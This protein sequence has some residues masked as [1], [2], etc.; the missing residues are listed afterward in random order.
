MS[1]VRVTV[2]SSSRTSVLILAAPSG[3]VEVSGIV[4]ALHALD[5][6]LISEAT[7]AVERQ[8][9]GVACR[10]DCT[11]CCYQLVPVTEME[12]QYL[13]KIVDRLPADQ[14]QAVRVRAASAVCRL[15][16]AGLLPELGRIDQLAQVEVESLAIRFFRTQVPCPFL[17]GGSCLIY[18]QR[19]L[20]CREYLVTSERERCEQ[21]G[22]ETVQ[23]LPMPVSL[24][25]HVTRNGRIGSEPLVLAL[26]R[27]EHRADSGHLLP[28]TAHLKLLLEDG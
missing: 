13:N 28:A 3:P 17:D 24:F 22:E 12:A 9:R 23:R 15:D 18:E 1:E 5:D 19:P 7:A 21:F 26:Q 27:A 2:R 10:L 8:G 11:A 25:S 16:A 20:A 14:G 6:A 4:P